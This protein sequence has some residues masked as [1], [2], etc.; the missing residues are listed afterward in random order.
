MSDADPAVSPDELDTLLETLRLKDLP[1][2]GWVRRRVGDPES[3]AAH[4]W[5]VSWL[6]IALLP[7]DL[8]LGRALM[9]AALHDLPEVEVGDLTPADGVSREEKIAREDAA[10]RRIA[11]SLAHEPRILAAFAAYEAQADAEARFVRQLDRLDMAFQAVIYAERGHAGMAEFVASA[12]RVVDH[13]RLRPLV[14]ACATRVGSPR[15]R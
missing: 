10:I 6:A 11:S 14:E 7:S 12:M 5:G 9:Y 3:V 13:P 1:R 15:H 8:D 2:A 4:S